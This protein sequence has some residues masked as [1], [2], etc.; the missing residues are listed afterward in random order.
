MSDSWQAIC[1]VTSDKNSQQHRADFGLLVGQTR[2]NIS[3]VRKAASKGK[4]Q[5]GDKE[6]TLVSWYADQ[7]H[8]SL[9]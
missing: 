4:L 7:A 1:L 3:S 9:T 6:Q 2:H 5:L 8:A